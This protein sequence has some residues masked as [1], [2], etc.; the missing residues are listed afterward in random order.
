MVPRF[1][2]CR[3]PITD[4]ASAKPGRCLRTRSDDATSA[5]T[6][7]AP[8]TR[9]VPSTR[10]PRRPGIV[11]K[12]ISVPGDINRSFIPGIK[13][14]PP[15]RSLPASPC[16]SKSCSAS[17]TEC[18]AT[19]PKLAGNIFPSHLRCGPFD[20]FDDIDVT[21]AAAQVAFEGV[22]DLFVGRVRI[23]FQEMHC[24]HDDARC[25]VA[26]LQTVFLAKSF[27]HRMK[28]IAVCQSLDGLDCRSV[29]LD[30]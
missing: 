1:R 29:G 2:T 30:R 28:S 16:L 22:F 15:A 6:V 7:R 8:I 24:G 23:G 5:W 12:S 20:G 13:L 10:I 11:P 14:W 21:G 17:S 25:T 19:Y 4:A 26:A 18:A 3:S 27:L 9:D